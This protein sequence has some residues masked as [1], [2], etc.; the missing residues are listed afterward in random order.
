ELDHHV[1]LRRWLSGNGQ[2]AA[3][4]AQ[5]G[6]GA[7]VLRQVRIQLGRQARMRA[8][9]DGVEGDD[10]GQEVELA[11]LLLLQVALDPAGL[12]QDRGNAG[13]RGQVAERARV[14]GVVPLGDTT[15]DVG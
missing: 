13:L 4:D 3:A 11:Q 1:D 2:G 12:D 9:G 6:P 5:V 8:G 15:G 7:A 14:E 10:Q